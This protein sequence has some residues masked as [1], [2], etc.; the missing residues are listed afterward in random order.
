MSVHVAIL[1]KQYIKLILDGTKTVESRL[2]IRPLVPY[3]AIKPGERIYMKASAGPFMATAVAEKVR[4][5]EINTVE[6]LR[7][8][9]R[10]Y[11]HL[12]RGDAAYWRWHKQKRSRCATLIWLRDVEPTGTGPKLAPSRG[13]AWFVLD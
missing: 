3:K 7:D 12:V 11:N 4:F 13:P 6:D 8:L 10:R 2:T 1:W 5:F 9:Y